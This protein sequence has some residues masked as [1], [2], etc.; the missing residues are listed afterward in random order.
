[1]TPEEGKAR[2]LEQAIACAEGY[3]E[4]LPAQQLARFI[5]L[6]FQGVPADEIAARD[7]EDLYGAALSHWLLAS[8][9]VP[10]T[11][12]LRVYNPD[13]EED[14]WRSTHTVVE[15][16]CDDM[17]FLV[18]SL[19]MALNREGLTIH[20]GIH[21]VLA[22]LRGDRGEILELD[23][24]AESSE[25]V[26][27]EAIIHLEVDRRSE[28][29]VLAGLARTLTRVLDEVRAVVAD[30]QPMLQQLNRSI[31]TLTANP[32][33]GIPDLDEDLEFLRWLGHNHFTFLG[34]KRFELSRQDDTDT[35]WE[36]PDSGL[37]IDRGNGAKR[38]SEA[39][40]A[41]PSEVRA[42]ARRKG[43]LILTKADRVASI[44]RPVYMDYV[45]IRRFD[46]EGEVVAEDRFLG[47]YAS[48]A[49]AAS[50]KDIP[51]LRRKAAAVLERSR[52]RPN[53]HSYKSLL[54]IL[55]TFPRDQLF[56]TSTADLYRI[57]VGILHLEEHQRVRLFVSRDPFQRFFSCLLFVPRER[58]HTKLRQRVQALFKQTFRAGSVDFSV[59]LSESVLARIQF[60]VHCPAGC[61]EPIDTEALEQRVVEILRS[62]Q[63]DLRAALLEH[64]GEEQGNAR[65][66]RYRH[67]FDA[68]YRERFPARLAVHDLLL[69]EELLEAGPDRLSM[70]LY[71]PAEAPQE[72]LRFKL[73]RHGPP[74]PLS[75][76]L[77]MLEHMGVEVL[78]EH[79]FRIQ[80]AG[81]PPLSLHD[82]GLRPL[83]A[84][85]LV[86]AEVKPLFQECFRRVWNGEVENDGF[87]RLVLAA[88]LH[89]RQIALLRAY[90]KY[91]KQ[92]G[93]TFSQPYIEDTL[94]AYPDLARLLIEL[95]EARLRPDRQ[96]HAGTWVSTL[97][98]RL[99]EGLDAVANLSQDRILRRFFT[100]IQAT[101]RSNYFQ[102][103]A[104]GVPKPYLS[105]KLDPAAIP[106]LPLP[107]PYYEIFVYS[108]RVE[109]V[110]LRGGEVAR[111]GLRW[112]D[113]PEDFR[114]E[115]LGLMKAQTVKNG[116]IVPVGAK[117]GFVVKQPPPD[118]GREAL[119]REVE[120]CYRS[121]IRGLL[122]ITDNRDGERIVPPPR[123]VRHDRDDPY[124][125]VAADKG[126]AAFSDLANAVSAEYGFWLGDAFASGGSAGYDH[127]RMGI[128]AR[129]AWESV[130]RHFRELGRD[131]Q[132]EPFTV[133]GI[134]DMSGD[135]FG[136]G[137]LLSS[138]IRL[139][140]AFDH[141]H[142]FIDPDP[143]P[144]AS[145][146]ERRRLFA[147]PRSSWADY[148]AERLS[149]GGGV[150]PRSSKSI[151]LA[152]EARRALGTEQA[153][154]TPDRLIQTLLRAPVDLLWNGGI[155]TYVKASHEPHAAAGDRGN[156]AVRI[157][158]DTL[159]CKVIGEGGNLGLT[160]AARVQY[161]LA[162]GRI[163]TD[164]IDNAGGVD[165]SDHEVNI[166]ILLDRAVTDGDLTVKQ[167]N[168]LLQEMTDEVAKLVLADNYLQA[169]CL[170][171]ANADAERRYYDEVQLIRDLERQG[172]LDRSLEGLPDDEELAGRECLSAPE[173][174]VLI[175]YAK[176][177]LF[178]RLVTADLHR[179]PF[180]RTELR[181]YFP[182]R[183]EPEFGPAM[184]EH[185]LAKEI[186]ATQVANDLVNRMGCTFVARLQELSGASPD[187]IARAYAL[188]REVF[189]A[190]R[191]RQDIEALDN[192]LPGELQNRLL[193]DISRLL[194]RSARHLL[195]DLPERFEVAEWVA[196]LRPGVE[197]VTHLL[198]RILAEDKK[199]WYPP[200]VQALEQQGLDPDLARRMAV[201]GPLVTGIDIVQLARRTERPL[202]TVCGAYFG[203]DECLGLH[204]LQTQATALPNINRWQK[205]ARAALRE[206]YYRVQRDIAGQVLD[207][208][209]DEQD[210]S[211]AIALWSRR[212]KGA[213]AAYRERLAEL[214]KVQT[215]DLAMLSVAARDL[216][217][218]AARAAAA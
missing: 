136:N 75:S 197:Q 13:L 69:S 84:K 41:L 146:E 144:A 29:K 40:M 124:L 80:P 158:A 74:I 162:G 181:R 70:N 120:A 48:P 151:V 31:A 52:L 205:L 207:A 156:E 188:V 17:P 149:A 111:G 32:P 180:F 1:M 116:V 209:P 51:V 46:A 215:S 217:G 24:P 97:A 59:H 82:F 20:L 191:C 189:G 192:H 68:A 15:L 57:A 193:L 106:E 176:I 186:L 183:L 110:H 67:A 58:Y 87:N 119:Q 9:H 38:I 95:F 130:K 54:H 174:A 152:P 164:F 56:H 169:Q 90:A 72:L 135:V 138:Q 148:D 155:G 64:S 196:A 210:G 5:P 61:D 122:D 134:G 105:L 23:G 129:G 98:A 65:F 53:S 159:R 204:W 91:L 115:I 123:T 113:R 125:V 77:P 142:I 107:R 26:A 37:G 203:L 85:G 211:A 165:C 16:V 195:Q 194:E 33:P 50:V 8:R 2:H 92:I 42:M 79:P 4:P 3:P 76:V 103:E 89:W 208:A 43:L 34:C 157:D 118:G 73:F 47:L 100:V 198:P 28:P 126:T 62:W 11:P 150:W 49:Y 147:L 117:G 140:A 218:L 184:A 36:L 21:P 179:D 154:F 133:A 104:Q 81:E 132:V 39:F 7:P 30:W 10:G 86:N 93:F 166:K 108:P 27:Y 109:G 178:R 167:R 94:A 170:S 78:D 6:Y 19:R 177:D 214:M 88:R 163:N 172:A 187:R 18:D 213:L 60:V 160:Q 45:G 171:L 114:T 143:D 35:L 14:S 44:H 127:K 66:G 141:R 139:L 25:R 190:E 153:R 22:V 128:T 96:A 145:L 200:A 173:H 206:E 71:H 199:G 168:L 175:G 161:A 121:F 99:E 12:S 182:A 212:H 83:S 55:E 202:E 112:S 102:T 101:V 185:R 137:M 216:G 63:D 201:L 131:I